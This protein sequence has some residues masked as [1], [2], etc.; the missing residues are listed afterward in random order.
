ML[1]S[2]HLFGFVFECMATP[3]FFFLLYLQSIFF[4]FTSTWMQK[5]GTSLNLIPYSS[6]P[7]PF[8]RDTRHLRGLNFIYSIS[9]I[10]PAS[11]ISRHGNSPAFFLFNFTYNAVSYFTQCACDRE[12]FSCTF[13]P[14]YQIV[15]PGI[16]K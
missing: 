9:L 16:E 10:F 3:F 6:N 15:V 13:N 7:S 5:R 1:I 14:M 8:Y 4:W 11:P 12:T 2:C